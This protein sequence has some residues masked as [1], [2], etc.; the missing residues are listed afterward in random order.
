VVLALIY[1]AG[2]IVIAMSVV[3]ALTGASLWEAG[4]VA[5]VE[6]S[7][8]GVWFYVLHSLWKRLQN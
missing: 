2:H 1:T 4:L 7:I 8:N 3:S 6:P 5:L